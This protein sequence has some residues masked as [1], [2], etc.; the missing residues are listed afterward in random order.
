MDNGWAIEPTTGSELN[1]EGVRCPVNVAAYPSYK[2]TTMPKGFLRVVSDEDWRKIDRTGEIHPSQESWHP[3]PPGEVVFLYP[4]DVTPEYLETRAREL[5]DE[6]WGPAHLLEI[7]VPDG[8]AKR[9]GPDLSFAGYDKGQVFS[10]PIAAKEGCSIRHVKTFPCTPPREPSMTYGVPLLLATPADM[11]A[12]AKREA[13]RLRDAVNVDT[14]FNFFVTAYHVGDYL[15]GSLAASPD[16]IQRLY[17]D[18]DFEACK[19]ICNQGKHLRV[20][21][22]APAAA[23][24]SAMGG[25]IGTAPLGSLPIGSGPVWEVFVGAQRVDPVALA[26]R[27]LAKL[28]A[29]FEVHGIPGG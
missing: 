3:F 14:V 24:Q 23:T 27:L 6:G 25:G 19:A 29:F 1:G 12:K 11:L 16:A 5:C 20:D 7:E 28:S 26:E 10:G 17:A 9:L 15:R 8:L 4:S 13:A 22:R 18:S 21:R 2:L